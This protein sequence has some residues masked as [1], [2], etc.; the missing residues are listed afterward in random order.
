M[1][2]LN[3]NIKNT[4]LEECLPLQ[5]AKYFI[6][7]KMLATFVPENLLGY[8]GHLTYQSTI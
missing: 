4:I 1:P 7:I 5:F 3:V 6:S 2:R 8:A